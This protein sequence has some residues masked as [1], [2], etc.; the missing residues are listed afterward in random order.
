MCMCN[1]HN[2]FQP[3]PPLS[4]PPPPPPPPPLLLSTT[5]YIQ[6]QLVH[7]GCSQYGQEALVVALAAEPVSYQQVQCVV[8]ETE[9]LLVYA[10][11][12]V[13]R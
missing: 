5:V 7:V 6:D 8:E 12:S 9:R 1:L 4:L 2:I 11:G 3:L 13:S 10:Y